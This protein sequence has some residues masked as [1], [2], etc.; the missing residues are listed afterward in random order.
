MHFIDKYLD[1]GMKI[2]D[3]GCGAGR[4]SIEFAKRGCKVTLLDISNEQL[5]IAKEKID[6]A[7]VNKNI[8]GIFQGD[9][10]DLSQFENEKFDL[11][12]CYGAPLSYILEC[13]EKVVLEFNRVLK[14]NGMLFVSV[15]NKW[16]VVFN[17]FWVINIPIFLVIQ[18]IGI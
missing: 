17:C 9:I 12:V 10:R 18:S 14:K 8:E 11:V 6:D 1:N 3:A 7:K 5:K 4:Y 2:L 15:N 16:G 13:R